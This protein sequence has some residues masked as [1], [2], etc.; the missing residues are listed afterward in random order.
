MSQIRPPA[1]AG[2]FYPDSPQE[3]EGI[4]E[5]LFQQ[6]DSERST[7]SSAPKAVIAPHAGYVY[8]G[9]TAAHAFQTFESATSEIQRVILVGPAHRVA[10][11]GAA[12]PGADAFET[13]LGTV[14]VDAEGARH[15]SSLPQVGVVP[16]AHALEHSL[17]VQLPFLQRRLESFTILPLVVGQASG[18]EVAETLDRVWGGSE[19]RIVISSDL[20]HYLP[21]EK[22][23]EVDHR[24]SQQILELGGD[25]RTDQAC[26]AIPINGLLRVAK[27]RGLRPHL[28]DLRNS[29]DT[30]GDRDQVVGYCAVAFEEP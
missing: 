19:T 11:P 26:G 17:E 14:E 28:L 22:A 8:S 4:V 25:L 10:I 3:L 24:T 21:Y 27:E 6:A 23:R 18:P 13:P 5:H 7:L 30:A 2:T 20:S 29:G 15:V 9:L 12:L 1:A 16:P